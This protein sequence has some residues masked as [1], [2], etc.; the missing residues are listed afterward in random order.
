MVFFKRNWI[1][2]VVLGRWI[3]TV[4]DLICFSRILKK[5]LTDIGL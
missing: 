3:L 1:Q 4:L 5:K 2:M